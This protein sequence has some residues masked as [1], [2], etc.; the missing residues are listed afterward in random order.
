MTRPNDQTDLAA[1]VLT[2]VRL[3][4]GFKRAGIA[5]KSITEHVHV[6]GATA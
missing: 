3:R 6:V 2:F 1:I 4:R 5:Q